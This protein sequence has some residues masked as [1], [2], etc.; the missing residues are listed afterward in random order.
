MSG[1]PIRK[2]TVVVF[3][4]QPFNGM[5]PT[6]HQQWGNV[7][8]DTNKLVSTAEETAQTQLFRVNRMVINA[9]VSKYKRRIDIIQW[10]PDIEDK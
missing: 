10:R 8:D 7:I 9:A 3:T 4:K 6:F 5:N 1:K 2:A